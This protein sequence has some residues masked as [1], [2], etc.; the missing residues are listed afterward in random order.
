MDLK[1]DYQE[2]YKRWLKEI[3]DKEIS[4]FSQEEYMR[5]RD[6]LKN[7]K[8][9]SVI[10]KDPIEIQLIEAYQKNI[11]FMIEDFISVRKLKII[12]SALILQEINLED[13]IETEKLLYQN[14]V[15][16]FKGFDKTKSLTYSKGPIDV[17]KASLITTESALESDESGFIRTS[18]QDSIIQD[19]SQKEGE[20]LEEPIEYNYTLIRIIKE[21]PELIGLDLKIYGPFQK[22]DV[23]NLPGKNANIL[24]NEKFAEYFEIT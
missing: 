14:L 3:N 1:K 24:V 21:T 13:L 6:L 5:M 18:K 17:E 8:D 22:E 20:N 16:T 15:S 19:S 7:I 11:S 12:N 23:V 2:L 10:D 9:L 4:N